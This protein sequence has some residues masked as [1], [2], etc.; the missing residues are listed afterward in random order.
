MRPVSRATHRAILGIAAKPMWRAKVRFRVLYRESRHTAKH[1]A[2]ISIK[3]L[4]SRR[5]D[6]KALDFEADSVEEGMSKLESLIRPKDLRGI[7][8]KDN[9]AYFSL[10]NPRKPRH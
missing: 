10:L 7:F 8:G 5:S 3:F 4:R 9:L 1:K 6:L 2:T